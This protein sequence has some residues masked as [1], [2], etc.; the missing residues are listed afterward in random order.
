MY[1]FSPSPVPDSTNFVE[2][3]N[4]MREQ[5]QN[6]YRIGDR[7]PSSP[8]D[9]L[10]YFECFH[11]GN[12]RDAAFAVLDAMVAAKVNPALDADVQNQYARLWTVAI[13]SED[14]VRALGSDFY[15]QSCECKMAR[16]KENC[17]PDHDVRVAA[18]WNEPEIV[19][20]VAEIDAAYSK[21]Y[22]AV[23]RRFDEGCGL[24]NADALPMVN[25]A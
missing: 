4:S 16:A 12:E 24:E 20:Q 11:M 1:T 2:A 13:Y 19:R 8:M 23:R 3:Y 5:M 9:Q 6:F 14:E 7:R 10:H 25:A 18:A 22:A 21:V 15:K 17:R